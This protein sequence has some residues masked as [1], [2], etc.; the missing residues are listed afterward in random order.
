[1]TREEHER[2]YALI[3]NPPPGSK[4]E[5]AKNYGIDL[6]L[7]LHNLT[8]TPEDRAQR[9]GMAA[10][11]AEALRLA[12][13]HPAHMTGDP[14]HIVGLQTAIKL[15]SER[16]ANFVIVG[17]FAGAFYGSIHVTVNLD[18]CYEQTAENIE[19]LVAVLNPYHPYLRG[20]PPGLPFIFDVK[21]VSQGMNFALQ[22]DLGDIDLLGR[23]EGVSD[24]SSFAADA[25]WVQLSDFKFRVA[26]LDALLR[27][28]RAAGRPRD[29]EILAELER[30]KKHRR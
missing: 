29:L 26:S 8:L 1:M 22:T 16:G 20:A 10:G 11:F 28:K 19:R 9:M 21:T 4:M 24:F 23:V 30:L 12:Y 27:S 3:Q 13:S 25:I 7:L 18:V 6:T 2:L 17:G 5:E 15:L 14:D